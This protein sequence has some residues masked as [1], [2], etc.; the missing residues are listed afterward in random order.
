MTYHPIPC[1]LSQHTGH[2]P[3]PPA[4]PC[5]TRVTARTR[6]KPTQN[7]PSPPSIKVRRHG[8][9]N[10]RQGCVQHE[11][12]KVIPNEPARTACIISL[13]DMISWPAPL[14]AVPRPRCG[15]RG[16]RSTCI[17]ISLRRTHV[18]SSCTHIMIFQVSTGRSA[19]LKDQSN[20]SSATGSS[21]GSWYGAR[22]GCARACSARTRF[23]GSNTSIF[24]RRSMAAGC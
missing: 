12:K 7:R 4:T 21:E 16:S 24:S 23:L 1:Q 19:S 10:S 20:F 6:S 2:S 8:L 15:S 5:H 18:P 22:Y 11:P 14:P 13:S 17:F 9:E 3:P